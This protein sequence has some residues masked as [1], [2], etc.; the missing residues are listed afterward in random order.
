MNHSYHERLLCA[1]ISRMARRRTGASGGG[2]RLPSAAWLL[3]QVGAHAAA[4]FAERL[5]VL[6]LSPP[7]AGILWALSTSGGLSQQAPA[8]H[9]HRPPSRLGAP[10]GH[11]E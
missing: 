6:G 11:L 10:G 5:S 7:H 9:L 2:D 8:E 3:A 1:R 4:K